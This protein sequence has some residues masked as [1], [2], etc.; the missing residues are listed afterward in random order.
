MILV[1]GT[2]GTGKS[3]LISQLSEE[4][5]IPI[6]ARA[7]HSVDGPVANLFEW[8]YNDVHTWPE[9]PLSIYDRHPLISEPIY[10]TLCRGKIAEGLTGYPATTLTRILHRHA[11][12]IVCQP[13]D[14]SVVQANAQ[15]EAQMEGVI[16]NLQQIYWAYDGILATYPLYGKTFR[17]D[18]TASADSEIGYRSLLAAARL[19]MSEWERNVRK[20]KWPI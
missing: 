16:S 12:L 13:E 18:Y 19:H 7:S 9:Q 20:I 15:K 14:F 10:G 5:N 17:Y 6:H 3:T 4:L 2:D 1:E 8:T 11:L